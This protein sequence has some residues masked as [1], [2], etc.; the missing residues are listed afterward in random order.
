MKVRC[1]VIL[2]GFFMLQACAYE[3]EE[4]LFGSNVCDPEQVTYS[5]VIS[6]LITTNCAIPACHDGSN[7]ALPN[8]S[9]YENVQAN[10]QK[11]K[12]RTAN[13]TMPPS[14]SGIILSAEQIDNIGC[15]VDNGAQNN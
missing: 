3:N 10:A 9:I 4:D 2:I 12:E 6:P 15:W 14:A 8:W 11:I 1:A 5:G 13:R 7:P